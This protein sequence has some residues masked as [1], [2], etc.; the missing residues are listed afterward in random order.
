M[1]SNPPQI[2][3]IH[4][5]LNGSLAHTLWVALCFRFRC[6]LMPTVHTAIPLGTGF[7]FSGSVLAC[8]FLAIGTFLHIP[9][10]AHPFGHSPIGER[11]TALFGAARCRYPSR[12]WSIT[13]P[14]RSFNAA[15]IIFSGMP[16][17]IICA[18]C[19]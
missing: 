19:V 5:H 15:L 3:T 8:G 7:C 4:V 2:A 17:L 18:I 14:A 10:L 1:T 6:V 12:V 11:T 16:C 13:C 9:I